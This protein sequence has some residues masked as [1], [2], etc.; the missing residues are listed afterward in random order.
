MVPGGAASHAEGRHDTASST[1]QS[2]LVD[3][4]TKGRR[5]RRLGTAGELPSGDIHAAGFGDA[6]G[7]RDAA[8]SRLAAG[9]QA[10]EGGAARV[11]IPRRGEA[12]GGGAG[13]HGRPPQHLIIPSHSFPNERTHSCT[14]KMQLYFYKEQ[15][16]TPRRTDAP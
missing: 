3:Q 10:K 11:G 8:S 13:H 15:K 12:R 2:G 1:P 6:A 4:S 5:R 7:G 9:E 14:I 16:F